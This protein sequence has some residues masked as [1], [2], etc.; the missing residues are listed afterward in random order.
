MNQPVVLTVLKEADAACHRCTPGRLRG[1][2]SNTEARAKLQRA[3]KG[4]SCG[5]RSGPEQNYTVLLQYPDVTYEKVCVGCAAEL[6][7]LEKT[8]IVPSLASPCQAAS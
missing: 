1:A 5:C 7:S 3:Y 2:V 8:D 4:W 6:T